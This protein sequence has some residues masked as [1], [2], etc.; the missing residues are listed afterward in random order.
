MNSSLPVRSSGPAFFVLTGALLLIS[1]NGHAFAPQ[2]QEQ[3]PPSQSQQAPPPPPPQ[4]SQPSSP[5]VSPPAPPR[6]KQHKVWTNDDVV[7][8]RSPADTYLAEREAQEAAD[9][10]AAARKAAPAKQIKEADLTPSLPSTSEETQRLIRAKQDQIGDLQDGMDRLNKDL[11]D[12]PPNRKPEMQQ[13]I[14]TFKDY[15]KK[16]QLE[17]KVLQDRLQNLAKTPLR[18]T[19]SAPPAPSPPPPRP[20]STNP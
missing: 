4:N 6:S 5:Q 16:A 2:V 19:P 7:S 18:E 20:S 9:A 15:L 13:Q 14:E 1:M 3:Q 17:L 11:P 12:A 8:L 10:E